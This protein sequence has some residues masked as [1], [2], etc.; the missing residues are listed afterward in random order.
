MF[1]PIEKISTTAE[2]PRNSI[3]HFVSQY[4]GY[5]IFKA[6]Y[7]KTTFLTLKSFAIAVLGPRGPK[8]C[9]Y[10]LMAIIKNRR[11]KIF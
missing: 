4:M 5:H 10:H 11:A 6:L 9:I 3:L 1:L 2:M 8:I 7:L